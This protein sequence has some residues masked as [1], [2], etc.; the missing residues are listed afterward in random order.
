MLLASLPLG[1]GTAYHLQ[2]DDLSR[3]VRRSRWAAYGQLQTFI[4][5]VSPLEFLAK[6]SPQQ[7]S[8]L[9]QVASL[10]PFFVSQSIMLLDAQVPS[11]MW[12]DSWVPLSAR[13]QNES[14]GGRPRSGRSG[15]KR[16]GPFLLAGWKEWLLRVTPS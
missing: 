14:G 4:Q 5:E 2:T 9:Q 11:E 1:G 7:R 13:L 12:Y 3:L 6:F 8:H 15:V 16:C 10:L